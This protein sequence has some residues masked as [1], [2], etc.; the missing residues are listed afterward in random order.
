MLLF[1]F[2]ALEVKFSK[3][4]NL[5]INLFNILGQLVVHIVKNKIRPWLCILCKNLLKIGK[6]QNMNMKKKNLSG[7]NTEGK[8]HDVGLSIEFLDMTWKK[9]AIK[10]KMDCSKWQSSAWLKKQQA[11]WRETFTMEEPVN[12]VKR[13]SVIEKN[14]KTLV[15]WRANV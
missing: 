1:I 15:Y 4:F 10:V 9:E 8:C 11:D 5:F 3:N 2:I 13:Q 6:K 14:Y 12:R 7:G